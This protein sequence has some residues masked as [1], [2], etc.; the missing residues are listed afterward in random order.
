MGGTAFA[1]DQT[2]QFDIPAESLGQALTDFSR[3]SSQQIVFSEEVTNGKRTQ[4]LHGRYTVPDALK[5]LLV[6]TDLTMDGSSNGVI[7]VRSK[8]VQ[9]ARNEG[10]A[11]D[12]AAVA[13]VEEVIVT[14]RLRRERLQDVPASVVAASGE[15][16]ADQN[17]VTA[18][19]LGS[20]APG[21][22]FAT[23][24]GRF[25]TG[26]AISI[27]GISTFTQSVAIQDSVG[28]VVDGIPVSRAKGGAFPNL[29]DISQIQILRGPQG[30]LFG[31]N[32]SAG[33]ISITT[34]DP[35]DAP[36][37]DGSI[38]YSTYDNRQIHASVSGP[39]LD[40]KLL[41]G[42]SIYSQTR[43]GDIDDVYNNSKWGNDI[44]KGIRGKLIFLPTEADR[45]KISADFLQENN[46]A[47][48]QTVRAF[49]STTPQYIV[50]ALSSI[51]GPTNNKIDSRTVDSNGQL[52]NNV[53]Q[54]GGVA[55]Q[56]DHTMDGYTLTAITGYRLWNQKSNSGTYNWPTPL[57]DGNTLYNEATQQY[58]AEVRIASPGE[59]R[60]RYVAG[61]FAYNDK[62]TSSLYDPDPGLLVLSATG[63][64]NPVRQQRNWNNNAKS[65]N[66]AVFGEAD[67]DLLSTLTLTA[68]VRGIHEKDDV[69]INGLPITPGNQR[70]VVPLGTTTGAQTTDRLIWRAGAKWRFDD[71]MMV[72]ASATTG[73]KGPGFNAVSSILGNPQ[74]VSAETSISYEAG[75]RSQLWDNRLTFN[76]TAYH[77]VYRNFQT[78]GFSLFPGTTVAQVIL[79]NAARLR[80]QG[81]ESEFSALLDDLTTVTANGTYIDA[82]FDSFPGAQCYATQ[83][84]SP[85]QCVNG[86]QNLTGKRLANTP[87]W[88]F[89][90]SAKREIPLPGFTWSGFA[91]MDYDWRSSIQWDVL[92]NPLAVE[93]GYGTLGASLGIH[94]PDDRYT[95]KVYGRNL[96]DQFHTEGI[97]VG[98][99][100][101][102]FLP[103]DYRRIVGINFA[104]KF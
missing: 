37:V 102:Q 82:G 90:L 6:G 64:P 96:T 66:Y 58:S 70:T 61:L 26:P 48:A 30:T 93:G 34:K 3:A 29:T 65:F 89:N 62:V 47:G 43:D 50:T 74:P 42:L 86:Q 95:I 22:T 23:D 69:G 45:L 67:F 72:Y 25:G 10:A 83:P 76:L 56:W 13:P 19:Q 31:K 35:T 39:V 41:A 51:A 2:Y 57:N 7:G 8:K 92:Q 54:A 49:L 73:F 24:P 11:A 103:V 68:G 21:L 1:A 80:T 27:R 15:V 36:L 44:Q 98:Q 78:Q 5:A 16:I 75:L 71:G 32:S 63:V 46:D 38:D 52:S 99:A 87:K 55:L 17:I 9:A 40:G 18:T 88:A 28:V 14:A 60:F 94:S 91:T 20:I 101:T 85:G 97:L 53:Q 84:A 12:T 104:A 100:I 77:A 79:S 59:D 81:F 4:G 33:V